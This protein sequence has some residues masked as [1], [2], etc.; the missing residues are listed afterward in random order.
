M[1][2]PPKL[3][4]ETLIV[5]HIPLV[6]CQVPDR[7]RCSMGKRPNPFY[8]TDLGITRTTSL[9]ERDLLQKETLLYSSLIQ[10]S[11]L[12]P[13]VPHETEGRLP[14]SKET[15]TSD[16][17][18]SLIFNE[19]NDQEISYN[20]SFHPQNS[21][22]NNSPFVLHEQPFH[23]HGA[24]KSTKQWSSNIRQGIIEGQEEQTH[25]CDCKKSNRIITSKQ[26]SA[27]LIELPMCNCAHDSTSTLF[28]DCNQGLE[29]TQDGLFGKQDLLDSRKCSCSSSDIQQ[30]RSCVFSDQSEVD[31][32]HMTYNSDSSCNSSDGVLVNFTA[33]YNKMKTQS[34]SN[35]SSGN[36]SHDSSYCSHSEMGAFYLDLQSSPSEPKNSCD[37]H[38][39]DSAMQTCLC[40]QQCSPAVDDNCNSYHL[41]CENMPCSSENSDYT[42]C[43]QSQARLV[44]ATQN[45]YKLV[46]CDLSSQSTPS[47]AGSSITSCSEDHAKSTSP[48]QPTEYYLFR[49]P[50]DKIDI[51]QC[52]QE[53]PALEATED[54]IEG[55]VYVNVASNTSGRQRSRSYDRNL[56][57]GPSPR[58]GS[59]ERMYSCPGKL[60]DSHTGTSQRSPPRRVTSFAEIAR[61]RKRS[62]NSPPLKTSGDSSIEFSPI[63]ENQKENNVFVSLDEECCHNLPGGSSPK[64]DLTTSCAAP[65][66]HRFSNKNS[67]ASLHDRAHLEGYGPCYN[68]E[69]GSKLE[70]VNPLHQQVEKNASFDSS[71]KMEGGGSEANAVIRYSKEQRPT[72]LPIQPFILHH[73]LSKQIP[74]VRPLQN[75]SASSVSCMY[76][77]PSSQLTT[78]GHSSGTS[79]SSGGMV[80]LEN[81]ATVGKSQNGFK[82]DENEK[83]R[84]SSPISEYCSRRPVPDAI[85]PS[86]LG[87]YSPVKNDASIL[88][89]GKLSS[90][91]V[92]P[93]R[94]FGINPPR[95]RSCPLSA[96]LISIR[97]APVKGVVSP[98]K[99]HLQHIRDERKSP[100]EAQKKEQGNFQTGQSSTC[101]SHQTVLPTSA[102]VTANGVSSHLDHHKDNQSR[103]GKA[104]LFNHVASGFTS[105]N[106]IAPLT[107]KWREYRRRNPLGHDRIKGFGC[108]LDPKQSGPGMIKKKTYLEFSGKS[109][110]NH[111][112]SR[113]YGQSVK[114]LQSYYS[115][116]FPDYFSLAEKPPAEFCLSPDGTTESISVDL[117]QK[118]GLVKAV[119][120]AVDLIVAHFGTS[121]DPGVK[122]KLG[123]STV[124]PNVG[125]LILKYLC[126]A[127]KNVLQDGLKAYIPDMIIGQRKNLPWIVIEASTQ[128]G[129]STKA[130]NNLFCKI[131]QCSELT[132]RSTRFNAFIFGLLNIRSLEFW[133]NHLYNHEDIIGVHY[134]PTGFLALSHSVCQSLFEELLLLLQPLSLLPFD[135]DLMFEYHVIQ[136]NM[137][138]QKKK[139]QLKVKQDLLQ[140]VHSTFQLMR[141]NGSN[142]SLGPIQDREDKSEGFTL[143]GVIA[144][145]AVILD[146]HEDDVQNVEKI[147]KENVSETKKD[148]QAGWWYQLMQSSQVYIE[149]S[150]EQSMFVNWE[151]RKKQSTATVLPQLSINTE[152]K[153]LREGVPEGAESQPTSELHKLNICGV[154][155]NQAESSEE[156]AATK[157]FSKTI[158]PEYSKNEAKPSWMGSPPESVLHELKNSKVNESTASNNNDPQPG[159]MPNMDNTES[160]QG[161]WLG[162]LF[163]ASVNQARKEETRLV[164]SQKNRLPSGWLGLDRSV[165]DLMVQ[166]MGAGKWRGLQRISE[167][168]NP[169]SGGSQPESQE[170]KAQHEREVKALCH[171][172]ATEKGQLSFKKGDVLR[173]ISKVDADWLLCGLGAERGLV[174]FTYVTH[175]EDEDY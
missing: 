175:P 54:L 39:G 118:K 3:T 106:H 164:K 102:N 163:G 41:P 59:L 51:D 86:P 100:K 98:S 79:S 169:Q 115:D 149:G 146:K 172:I 143:K 80:S 73:P 66:I 97:S 25:K 85:R 24:E 35:L 63:L 23:L 53:E 71:T 27:D 159:K 70:P 48:S 46:T 132:S 61:T 33:I 40:H 138:Q 31:N 144:R 29:N 67:N 20:S 103:S 19:N 4:G 57:K 157:E 15:N 91:A 1:D 161:M 52:F 81:I 14:D 123:N 127:M 167:Q 50:E 105:A 84:N 28:F 126:P 58:L 37:I 129:P 99:A 60:S 17:H 150:S 112:R 134:L 135:L 11:C 152:K 173:V 78:N 8:H 65:F 64:M 36:M 133:F 72:T 121:R 162:R 22:I 43:F 38:S 45:Y 145:D 166:T 140:S 101:C 154:L 90:S 10:A 44:V 16:Q 113:L 21:N 125:H 147:R 9:P 139:E 116:F 104:A 136:M 153:S 168:F 5:H 92:S 148:K 18:N 93:E 74:R 124:S 165:Y 83:Q 110:V 6:H 107:L 76:S 42:A 109:G 170:R 30:S 49:Q 137:E 87:S 12:P 120:T 56:D 62:G 114:Q 96:N 32:Q 68:G 119:N 88:Q 174:P 171:H 160:K 82:A 55:Q 156:A 108:N 95:S 26:A 77:I 155:S 2:S 130:L 111:I 7:K 131:S 151:K 75:H 94:N 69:D 142:V 34:K 117:L 122:A 13:G 47:P 89:S 141:N 158:Q 128:L